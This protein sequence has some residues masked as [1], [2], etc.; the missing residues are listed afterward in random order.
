MD[1]IPFLVCYTL[2]FNNQLK[3]IYEKGYKKQKK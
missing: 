2:E 1:N 3:K